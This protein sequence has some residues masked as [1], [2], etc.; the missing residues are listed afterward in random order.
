MA[1]TESATIS[2]K[3]VTLR[4]RGKRTSRYAALFEEVLKLP[5]GK[6]KILLPKET[7]LDAA[8]KLKNYISFILRQK[9]PVKPKGTR[10]FVSI[11]NDHKVVVGLTKK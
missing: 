10:F 6:V 5:N 2:L 1:K 9:S 3:D 11:T 8:I 7:T 4:P